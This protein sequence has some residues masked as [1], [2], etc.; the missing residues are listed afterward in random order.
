MAHRPNFV[1]IMT[2]QHSAHFMDCSGHDL[3]WTPNLDRLA[4]EGIQ[5]TSAYC[6]YPLSTPS[7]MGFHDGD[8]PDQS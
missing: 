4:V 8:L 7:R 2:D 3:I 5:F 1:V 6:P